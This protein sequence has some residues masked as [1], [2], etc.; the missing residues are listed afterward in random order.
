MNVLLSTVSFSPDDWV[1]E[2]KFFLALE[3]LGPDAAQDAY[4]EAVEETEA[5]QVTSS[6]LPP[7]LVP[8]LDNVFFCLDFR[9]INVH[10]NVVL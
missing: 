9:R 2:K 8:A 10:M 3:S 1:Q 4:Q 6:G 5:T 7:T